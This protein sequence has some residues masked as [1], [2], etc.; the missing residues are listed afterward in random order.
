MDD[1]NI[2]MDREGQHLSSQASSPPRTPPSSSLPLQ[3][4][5]P[6]S[7]PTTESGRK[8]ELSRDDRLRIQGAYLWGNV[9]A[10]QL[11]TKTG[12]SYKQVR[13]A[14]ENPATPQKSK[15]RA[16][17][18]PAHLRDQLVTFLNEDPKHRDLPWSDLR[19]IIPGLEGIGTCQLNRAMQE[20]GFSRQ[21]RK[22]S[23]LSTP[24]TR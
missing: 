6:N 21:R 19:Y 4:L 8:K 14:L 3:E 7:H 9:S 18:L 1:F 10:R 15:P 22:K 5:Q 11:A 20:L 17:F 24:R 16:G 12:F 23:P 13:Y 2:Y